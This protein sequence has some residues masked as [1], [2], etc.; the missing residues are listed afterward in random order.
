MSEVTSNSKM[1]AWRKHRGSTTPVWEEVEVPATPDDG[2]L[3]K[4]LASG[5]CHSDD[6]LLRIE[7]QPPHF[8][9]KFILGHEGC[10]R[11]A[12]VGA[13]NSGK[14]KVGDLVALLAV[15]GCGES[16]CPEC[17]RDLPQLCQKGTHHGIGQ[18]GFYAPYAAVSPRAVVPLPE[19][20][21]AKII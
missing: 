15:P 14:L 3:V 7:K 1:F 20:K 5:V 17:S 19:G 8:K 13:A 9:E 21:S 4:L 12:E 18:D 2:Y 11:I 6:A 10:G 16:D